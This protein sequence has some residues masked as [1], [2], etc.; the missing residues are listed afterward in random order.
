MYQSCNWN[1]LRHL[2][3]RNGRFQEPSLLRSSSPSAKRN[4]FDRK[5]EE[6]PP[7][8]ILVIKSLVFPSWNINKRNLAIYYTLSLTILRCLFT[9]KSC[10]PCTVS[11]FKCFIDLRKLEKKSPGNKYIGSQ[12]LIGQTLFSRAWISLITLSVCAT[13]RTHHPI[14]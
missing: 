14:L 9:S 11:F 4:H 13:T 5:P 3:I 1:N 6:R 8:C 12:S 2:P 10:V 7:M